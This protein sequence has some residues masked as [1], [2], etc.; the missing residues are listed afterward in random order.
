MP[1]T[2]DVG[3]DEMIGTAKSG[4]AMIERASLIFTWVKEVC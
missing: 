4:H 3:I 2:S 1:V